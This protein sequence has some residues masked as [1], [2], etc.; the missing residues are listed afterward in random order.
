[1][2]RAVEFLQQVTTVDN[3]PYTA[4]LLAYALTLAG[5]ELAEEA[6][7]ILLDKS[8]V[9]DGGSYR[10]WALRDIY[11]DEADAFIFSPSSKQ[12]G[13]VLSIA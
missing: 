8:I 12:S 5:N 3:D 4:A 7:R 1:M 11:G 2:T 13:S 10:Y 9:K 6:R